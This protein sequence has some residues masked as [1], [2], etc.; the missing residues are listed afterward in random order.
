MLAIARSSMLYSH[1][2]CNRVSS[3]LT[4]FQSFLSPCC[5]PSPGF[6]RFSKSPWLCM[7]DVLSKQPR[8]PGL[9]YIS[10]ENVCQQ[11]CSRS[12]PALY[13]VQ[14]SYDPSCGC[15]TLEWQGYRYLPPSRLGLDLVNCHLS[16]LMVCNA[17]SEQLGST[18]L[19]AILQAN[20]ST[21]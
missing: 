12:S 14:F 4:L 9:R 19:C 8:L 10:A 3:F 1:L 15:S 20:L 11:R 16:S 5:L 17:F 7:V 2:D 6:V 21:C 13:S 18:A